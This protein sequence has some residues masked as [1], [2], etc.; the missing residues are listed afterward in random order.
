MRY[1][2]PYALSPMTYA[3]IPALPYYFKVPVPFFFSFF[4]DNF[5]YPGIFGSYPQPVFHH[6]H[7]LGCTFYFRKHRSVRFVFYPAIDGKLPGFFKCT[8]PEEDSLDFSQNPDAFVYCHG[9][10]FQYRANLPFFPD[11]S[12]IKG[13]QKRPPWNRSQFMIF[14]L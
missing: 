3:S 12:F 4:H 7:S 13:I 8:F 2:S 5:R 11:P 6:G 14:L 9:I 10:C 1:E